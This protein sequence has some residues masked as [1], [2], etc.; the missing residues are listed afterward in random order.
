M[1]I[2][3]IVSDKPD[4]YL[5]IVEAYY[6]HEVDLK[7]RIAFKSVRKTV[8][9]NIL[10]TWLNSFTSEEEDEIAYNLGITDD[11]L[12]IN[13]PYYH[14][15]NWNTIKVVTESVKQPFLTPEI[16]KLF[17]ES[18]SIGICHLYKEIPYV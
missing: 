11:S 16:N 14:V 6:N 17:K 15:I 3:Y 9:K 2:Q 12:E 18:A 13:D 10:H 4:H 7:V 5:H 1:E 8:T